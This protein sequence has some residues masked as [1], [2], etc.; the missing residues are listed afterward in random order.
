MSSPNACSSARERSSS[1]SIGSSISKR[2]TPWARASS[3]RRA[4]LK[5]LT[6]IR[7]AISCL[8]MPWT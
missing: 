5:R 8:A 3:S 7:C 4:I 2:T 1:S 6:S